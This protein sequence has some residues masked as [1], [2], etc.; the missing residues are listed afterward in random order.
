VAP[1]E[2]DREELLR[3]YEH[4]RL[5]EARSCPF[6]GG[7]QLAVFPGPR[8]MLFRRETMRIACTA[9]HAMGPVGLSP[10]HA[11]SLWNGASLRFLTQPL[12]TS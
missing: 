11:I 12:T 4:P 1:M 5:K 9:C 8:P 6:C 10:E 2:H 3:A 7:S